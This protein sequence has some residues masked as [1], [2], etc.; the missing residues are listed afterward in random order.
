MPPQYALVR[1]FLRQGYRQG[2]AKTLRVNQ[3]AGVD[4]RVVMAIDW[5][6]DKNGDPAMGTLVKVRCP[7][8]LVHHTVI[9]PVVHNHSQSGAG[10]ADPVDTMTTAVVAIAGSGHK[11]QI[12]Q[13]PMQFYIA[14]STGALHNA[15]SLISGRTARY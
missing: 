14:A 1:R 12:D 5:G 4:R 15:I 13:L 11:G 3:A 10:F 2:L 9:Q 8:S 7:R 6:A